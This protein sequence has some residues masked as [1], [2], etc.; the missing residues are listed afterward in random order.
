MTHSDLQLE[1]QND[2]NSIPSNCAFVIYDIS[3]NKSAD[4]QNQPSIICGACR[5]GYTP[6]FASNIISKCELI[7]GNAWQISCL[8]GMKIFK[9]MIFRSVLQVKIITARVFPRA[10][11]NVCLVVLDIILIRTTN[12]KI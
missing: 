2:I 1:D 10:E 4:L 3:K 5:P 6:S 9:V 8:I 12:A 7:V 11:I